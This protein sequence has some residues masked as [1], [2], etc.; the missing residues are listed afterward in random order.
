MVPGL[1]AVLGVFAQQAM[2]DL[3]HTVGAEPGLLIPWAVM[4]VSTVRWI[5]LV[6]SR[7]N[8]LPSPDHTHSR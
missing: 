6:A 4:A 1:G 7:S 2:P 3:A 8:I 5:P